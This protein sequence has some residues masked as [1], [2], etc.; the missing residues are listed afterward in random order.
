MLLLDTVRI[1][2]TARLCRVFTV[3]Y[4]AV[5][6]RGAAPITVTSHN[7]PDYVGECYHQW[8]GMVFELICDLFEAV[9][10]DDLV[11][12]DSSEDGEDDD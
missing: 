10:G 5:N 1:S 8:D 12:T 4:P 11:D 7:D 9:D 6:P 3:W 2:N